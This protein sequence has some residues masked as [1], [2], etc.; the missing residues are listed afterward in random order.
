MLILGF[1]IGNTVTGPFSDQKSAVGQE[2]PSFSFTLLGS[3][4][5]KSLAD[6]K[7]EVILLNLTR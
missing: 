1:T 3:N 6:Y 7:G 4:E 5:E 2:A